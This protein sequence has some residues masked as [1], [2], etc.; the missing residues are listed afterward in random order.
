MPNIY[1]LAGPNGSGKSTVARALIPRFL[2]CAEFVNADVIAHGLSAFKPEGAAFEAGRV[3]LR[4][5]DELAAEKMDFAF[6][7]T[8]S[9]RTFAHGCVKSRPKDSLSIFIIFGCPVQ[10]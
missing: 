3:M 1:I 2:H 6:E 9:S 5:L 4:R 10:I 7:T 8:L